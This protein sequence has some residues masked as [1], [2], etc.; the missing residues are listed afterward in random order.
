MQFSFWVGREKQN[1][2]NPITYTILCRVTLVT[3]NQSSLKSSTLA[4]LR[5]MC[6]FQSKNHLYYL[7]PIPYIPYNPTTY[8]YY[9]SKRS[10][11]KYRKTLKWLVL[12]KNYSNIIIMYLGTSAAV[13]ISG[14]EISMNAVQVIVMQRAI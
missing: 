1:N 13:G 6:A 12:P 14:L 8:L 11:E 4:A 9:L 3:P 2:E 7:V 5:S 10:S